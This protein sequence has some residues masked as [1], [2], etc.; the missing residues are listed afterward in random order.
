MARRRV[1]V[2]REARTG[3]ATGDASWTPR[4]A[5][6]AQA[7]PL[8]ASRSRQTERRAGRGEASAAPVCSRS[9]AQPAE[10]HGQRTRSPGRS[11]DGKRL[12]HE[13]RCTGER[14]VSGLRLQQEVG[15][16][17]VRDERAVG[18]LELIEPATTSPWSASF[19]QRIRTSIS[20]MLLVP[21]DGAWTPLGQRSH[22]GC[23]AV[24]QCSHLGGIDKAVALRHDERPPARTQL[25]ELDA[26]AKARRA[27]DDQRAGDGS[28]GQ[29]GVVLVAVQCGVGPVSL[30]ELVRAVDVNV[31]SWPRRCTARA[32]FEMPTGS[33]STGGDE[34]GGA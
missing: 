18:K 2:P 19:S 29:V 23:L 17:R 32:T 27:G 30:P 1:R 14:G 33:R 5:P 12:P 16:G 6:E 24:E 7:P 4:G 20:G 8:C 21:S 25:L 9:S 11:R 34:Q 15:V 28:A 31:R 13:N 10:S 26:A 22:V 3:G